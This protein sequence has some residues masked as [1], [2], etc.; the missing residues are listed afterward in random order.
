MRITRNFKLGCRAEGG[1]PVA[2]RD[3][4]MERLKIRRGIRSLAIV[5]LVFGA[6]S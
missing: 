3:W 6:L 4:L 2:S 1:T 5:G